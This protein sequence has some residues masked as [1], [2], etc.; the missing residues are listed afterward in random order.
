MIC[1]WA[2]QLALFLRENDQIE[3]TST[4]IEGCL[5][6]A[7]AKKTRQSEPPI[8]SRSRR[9]KMIENEWNNHQ[10]MEKFRGPVVASKELD[11][12]NEFDSI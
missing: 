11:L 8:P 5:D 10:M 9:M 4:E 3:Q 1:S 7:P 2:D 6:A 12:Q